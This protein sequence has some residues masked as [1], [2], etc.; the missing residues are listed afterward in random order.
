MMK[1]SDIIG[2]TIQSQD[3]TYQNCVSKEVSQIP[4][5]KFTKPEQIEECKKIFEKLPTMV[6]IKNK[7]PARLQRTPVILTCNQ[8]PWTG[9]ENERLTLQNRMFSHLNLKPSEVLSGLGDKGPDPRFYAEIFEYIR[10]EITND[11][12][13]L[14]QPYSEYWHLIVEKL[15]EKLNEI[16]DRTLTLDEH[17]TNYVLRYSRIGELLVPP[18][19]YPEQGLE[20]NLSKLDITRF[21]IDDRNDTLA[22]KLLGWMSKLREENNKDYFFDFTD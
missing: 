1:N 22:G 13:W 11:V 12:L 5:L 6:N 4:E 17:I 20:D 15:T 8:V 16:H 14:P 19:P 18:E 3:F 7:E 10:T 9:F 2:Q 21:D